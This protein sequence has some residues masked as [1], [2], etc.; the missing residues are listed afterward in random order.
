MTS[1][2]VVLDLMTRIAALDL[3]PLT[4]EETVTAAG[5]LV[6]RARAAGAT[7]VHVRVE[8]PNVD[9]QPPG[10]GFHDAA[11][12]GPGDW[13]LVKRSVGLFETTDAEASLR[14]DGAGHLVL[15]GIATEMAVLHTAREA[16]ELGFTVTVAEDA[17]TGLTVEGHKEGLAELA[18]LGTVTTTDAVAF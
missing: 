8:R 10:S 16:V 5:R 9:E 17:C 1:A 6:E 2:L 11:Q 3:A 14:E 13:E 12:P 18:T 15:C 4:G 7:V